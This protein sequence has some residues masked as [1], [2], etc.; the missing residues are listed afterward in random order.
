MNGAKTSCLISLNPPQYE[1]RTIGLTICK[2]WSNLH[3]RTKINPSSSKVLSDLKKVNFAF[4]II[5]NTNVLGRYCGHH[6]ADI[7]R[8]YRRK[9]EKLH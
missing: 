8:H 6:F 5:A 9:S 2:L 7:K 3:I 4:L 1:S